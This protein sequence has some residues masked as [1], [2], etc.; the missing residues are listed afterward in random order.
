MVVNG[1]LPIRS[2]KSMQDEE[3]RQAE[4]T[5]NR[6][7]IQ[8]LASHVRQCF[9]AAKQARERDAEKRMLKGLRQ[10]RGEYEPEVLA[11]IRK[12]GGSEIYMMLTSNKCRAAASWLRD[13]MLGARDEKPWSVE[14]TAL[15]ELPPDVMPGL[16]DQAAQEALQI[17][18]MMGQP[19]TQRS[20]RGI[21][22]RIKDDAI[23]RLQDEARA[24][25]SRMETKMEDQ[26]QEGGLHIALGQ[27]IDDITTFPAAVIKGPVI[28]K[29]PRLSWV[30]DAEGGYAMEVTEDLAL[31]WERVDPFMFYPSPNSSRVEDGYVVERHK[32]TRQDVDAMVGV[33]GYND[34]ALRAVLEQYGRGGLSNWLTD[35]WAKMQAE[36]KVVTLTTSPEVTIDALQYWGTVPGRMLVEWGLAAE[37]VA[38]PSKEYHCEVWLI[39]HWVVKATLNPDP[40]GRKP[41]YKASYEEIPGVFWGNSVADLVRDCQDMCN[42][43]A[44]AV[45]NNMGLASGPQVWVNTERLP[46]GE[47]VTQMYPWKIWQGTNDPFGSTARAIDF[48]QPSS[49]VAELMGVYERFAVLADEYSGVPRYMTG[50]ANV[51]GAGRT[52]SGMSMLM[53]NAGKA[54]KQVISNIDLN[55]MEPL[56]SRL[57][58]HN[59]KYS[60]DAALKGDVRVVARGVNALMTKEQTQVRR[61]EFLALALQNPLVGQ[62]LGEEAIAELLREGA[63]LLDMNTNKII[64]TPEKLRARQALLAMQQQM[65]MQQTA[66]QQIPVSKSGQTLADGTDVTDNFS[67]M[68]T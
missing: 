56:I 47:D 19:L 9:D 1:V 39:G 14:P 37:E 25:L 7:E 50:D 10:R 26:L 35:D 5:N 64:P 27:F 59:M 34:A 42:A 8:S 44:R 66:M 30:Q 63:K 46:E 55:V 38:D 49:N 61:N 58:Y 22:E 6:P 32:L 54:I 13:V 62:I 60:E 68:R 28:R 31:E 20:L 23:S 29:R 45:S 12:G 4:A 33:P 3:R 2:L 48:F 21:A 40:L 51:G 36:G 67:P 17:E 57:Y 16:I 65:A 11:D 52:A 24:R 18:E 15:P 41:Y 53:G 43:A